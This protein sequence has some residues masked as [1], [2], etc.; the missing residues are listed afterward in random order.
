MEKGTPVDVSGAE[1]GLVLHLQK[2]HNMRGKWLCLYCHKLY[3]GEK[4]FD[5][6]VEKCKKIEEKQSNPQQRMTQK[7]IVEFLF[8]FLQE[9]L[10]I[11]AFNAI[12]VYGKNICFL[13]YISFPEGFD[14]KCE[15]FTFVFGT[16]YF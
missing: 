5:S 6:H 1:Q 9:S 10:K 13:H 11:L 8:Y 14:F 15:V 2:E 12:F 4:H 16:G 3:I 7:L